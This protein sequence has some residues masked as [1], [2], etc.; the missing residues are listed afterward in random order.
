MIFNKQF[1][2]FLIKIISDVLITFVKINNQFQ[3]NCITLFS[4]IISL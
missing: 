1:I 3:F 2:Q 4:L